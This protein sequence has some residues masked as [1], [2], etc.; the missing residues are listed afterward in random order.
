[1]I[2]VQYDGIALVMILLTNLRLQRFSAAS[3]G[4]MFALAAAPL[5]VLV[6]V[7]SA[8]ALVTGWLLRN[9]V[10]DRVPDARTQAFSEVGLELWPPIPRRR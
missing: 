6:E 8:F 3:R 1:M 4:P 5:H 2:R 7:V 10:G 9:L